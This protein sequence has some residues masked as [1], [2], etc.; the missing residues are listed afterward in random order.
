MTAMKTFF[1]ASAIAAAIAA[2]P[3]GVHAAGLGSLNVFSGLGQPLRAQIEL[4]ATP[5]ELESLTAKIASAETFRQAG[6][7]YSSVMP[8][9]RVAVERR[10]DAAVLRLTS[11][12]PLNEPFVDLLLD[13]N[14]SSGRLIREYT[15]LL[16]PV[17]LDAPA[18]IAAQPVASAKPAGARRGAEAFP[19]EAAP[20]HYEVRHGDTLHDIAR[21]YRPRSATVDQ[22][23]VA[24]FRANAHAFEGGNMG[25]L[26]AESVLSLP[27]TSDVVSVSPV[28]AR[29]EVL[30][31]SAG[32]DAYRRR[33]AGDAAAID[34]GPTGDDGG[35]VVSKTSEPARVDAEGDRIEISGSAVTDATPAAR[36]E[37]MLRLQSLEEE[38]VARDKALEEANGRLA[39]L[40]ESM[41]E[42]QRLLEIRSSNPAQSPPQ[43]APAVSAHLQATG[44]D[45][46]GG[47]LDDPKLLAGGGG[48]LALLL[49]YF[50]IKLRQRRLAEQELAD[51]H[52]VMSDLSSE[53]HSVFGA[54]GAQ[55]VA[56]AD[57]GSILETDFSESD[58]SAIDANEG[59]DPIAEADVYIA[60]GRDAQAEEILHDALKADSSRTAIF[61]K[62]LEIYASRN[63]V[64][65]FEDVAGDLHARTGGTG[66]D[67]ERAAEL[68]RRID[69]DNRLYGGP[70]ESRAAATVTEEQGRSAAGVEVSGREADASSALA[71]LETEPLDARS[72]LEAAPVVDPLPEIDSHTL[73]FDFGLGD[74]A[75]AAADLQPVAEA[76][77]ET[78]DPHI[79]EFDFHL[80]D[81][82]VPASSMD[83][84]MSATVTGNVL[85]FVAAAEGEP[86]EDSR[87][88]EPLSKPAS[89]DP[90]LST[91]PAEYHAPELEE[92][93]FD[94]SLLDFDF[95]FN[96][97]EPQPEPA[98]APDTPVFEFSGIELELDAPA[99]MEPGDEVRQEI[100]AKLE[101]A[102][103]YEDMGDK[104][105]ARALIEEVLRDGSDGQKDAARRLL[106]TVARV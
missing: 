34:A 55:R 30:A 68:G 70:R 16:D 102:R 21:E 1:Q 92:T 104:D 38:L 80:G 106:K 66:P 37:S 31:H 28:Q 17:P 79:L 91:P 39:A 36:A 59:V 35:S 12:R 24:L 84:A 73:D 50:G 75:P 47:L 52:A 10:G 13:L 6:L 98:A 69:P 3:F 14:W 85:E 23:L 27:S 82:P 78:T 57:S 29:R 83:E 25:R 64:R 15:F 101:L 22:M 18:G 93:T 26:R 74:V 40:E 97:D 94:T 33:L 60:Y 53:I 105:G 61:L 7:S 58:F 63:S 77:P 19:P 41:R 2:V 99:V 88:A 81:D 95:D 4:K 44:P 89:A 90:D 9:L 51:S 54:S 32:F 48:I 45:G 43:T 72:A 87:L 65:Q 42:M 71:G 67:W 20:G 76:V 56:T 11:D 8:A 49:G 62:L 103:A 96:F 5:H 46:G 100:E 86:D